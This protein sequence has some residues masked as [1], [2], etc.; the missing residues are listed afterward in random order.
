M[1]DMGNGWFDAEN[2]LISTGSYSVA[3]GRIT[4]GLCE[5]TTVSGR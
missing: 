3:G 2:G 4:S 5:E 1:V